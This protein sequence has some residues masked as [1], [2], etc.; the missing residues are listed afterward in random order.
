M[1]KDLKTEITKE[2]ILTAACE[3]FA[4]FGYD[5]ATVNQICH[6]HGISKGLV[7]HNFESKENLYLRCVEK[8]SDEFVSYMSQRDFGTDFKL[9]M[10]ERCSFF[11]AHPYYS[12]LIFSVVLTDNTDFSDKIKKAKEKFDEYN[13]SVYLNVIEKIKLRSGIS[14]Q[15]VT[16]YYSLLQN[17]LN[18]YL[19]GIKSQ[20]NSFD[21]VFVNHEKGLEKILDFMLYGIAE[22]EEKQ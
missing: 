15:D 22:K 7:Y 21:S 6:K 17:I 18:G 5:G 20:E 4:R 1:K 9:Y 12:R 14:K 8:A 13:K 19:I 16:E 11:D 2:K 3:E 10:K